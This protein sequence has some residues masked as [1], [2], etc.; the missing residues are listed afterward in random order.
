MKG[1]GS[2]Y[3]GHSTLLPP[4]CH[5]AG[6]GSDREVETALPT[7]T[8]LSPQ[9]WL[10]RCCQYTSVLKSQTGSKKNTEELVLHMHNA[11]WVFLFRVSCQSDIYPMTQFYAFCTFKNKLSRVSV[12]SLSDSSP[13]PAC[14]GRRASA[15]TFASKQGEKTTTSRMCNTWMGF[16]RENRRKG[17]NEADKTELREGLLQPV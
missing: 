17:R 10:P 4:Q 1:D 15:G 11:N 16:P 6:P 12:Y 8:V 3:P 14:F 5:P 2:E 9:Y 7:L 13:T